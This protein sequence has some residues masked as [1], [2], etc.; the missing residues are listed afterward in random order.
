MLGTPFIRHNF[1]QLFTAIYLNGQKDRKWVV[2]AVVLFVSLAHHSNIHV[3]DTARV[4]AHEQLESETIVTNVLRHRLKSFQ[5]K[6]ETEL[7]G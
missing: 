1:S 3:Q 2:L 6:L 4:Y 5:Q 7:T